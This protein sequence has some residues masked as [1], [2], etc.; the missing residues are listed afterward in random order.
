MSILPD[1]FGIDAT[2]YTDV[3]L[4]GRGAYGSVF[5]ASRGSDKAVVALKVVESEADLLQAVMT[6]IEMLQAL[7]HE[8]V[9][10]LLDVMTSPTHVVL[11]L[12]LFTFDLAKFAKSFACPAQLRRVIAMQ[13]L[14]G[15]RHCH[16]QNIIHQDIKPQNILITPRTLRVCLADF[17][18]ARVV[19]DAKAPA[20]SPT[21]DDEIVTLWYRPPEVMARRGPYSYNIDLWSLGCVWAELV[22]RRPLYIGDT[23][24]A[25][26]LSISQTHRKNKRSLRGKLRRHGASVLEIDLIVQLL[27]E[28]PKARMRAEQALLHQY[29]HGGSIFENEKEQ[30]GA[31]ASIFS[32]I[33]NI[34]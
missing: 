9:V 15:L 24:E 22:L 28:D 14:K 12:E 32:Y 29:F 33:K 30:E 31:M 2:K 25:I 3:T 6:E 17:G 8:N 19:S 4:I 7:Q 1:D 11:E 20:A 16:Q 18:M 13:I 5:K 34:L 27:E 10:K 26:L 21:E 23:E